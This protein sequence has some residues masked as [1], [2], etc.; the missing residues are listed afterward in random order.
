MPLY[1]SILIKWN[2]AIPAFKKKPKIKIKS[3]SITNKV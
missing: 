1:I 2:G 3:H